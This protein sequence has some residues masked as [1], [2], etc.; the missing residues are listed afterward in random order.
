MA[1]DLEEIAEFLVFINGTVLLLIGLI[2]VRLYF[3]Y[4]KRNYL[5][6]ILVLF[7]AALQMIFSEIDVLILPAAIIGSIM[8]ILIL[9]MI[10][11][12]EKVPFNFDE[13]Q[14]PDQ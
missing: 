12:P 3:R 13:P 2:F 5:L 9:V 10:L 8:N 11:F 1:E 7:S 4:R 6:L 14:I